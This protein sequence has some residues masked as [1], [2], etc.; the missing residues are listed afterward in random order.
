MGASTTLA[1]LIAILR[2]PDGPGAFHV[3]SLAVVR[4]R[5]RRIYY[6]DAVPQLEQPVYYV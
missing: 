5:R 3:A 6:T 1:D 4:R 2:M